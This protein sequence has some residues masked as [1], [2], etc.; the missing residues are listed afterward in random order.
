LYK[1]ENDIL[2]AS[3]RNHC[4]VSNND[5]GLGTNKWL[6]HYQRGFLWESSRLIIVHQVNKGVFGDGDYLRGW[7]DHFGKCYDQSRVTQV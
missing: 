4:M 2:C 3:W 5:E 1:G 7:F 6:V